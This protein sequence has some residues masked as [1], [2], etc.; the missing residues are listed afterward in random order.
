MMK[1]ILEL[2]CKHDPEY[3]RKI[4]GATETEIERLEQ[5]S[6]RTLPKN[7]KEFLKHM[8]RDMGDLVIPRSDFNISTVLKTYEDDEYS[9]PEN[10]LFIGAF[11]QDPHEDYYLERKSDVEVDCRVVRFPFDADLS[12]PDS[13][14]VAYSS[15]SDML[16]S[17][18]FKDKRMSLLPAQARLIPL[19]SEKAL[20]SG[21]STTDSLH[22]IGGLAARMGFTRLPHT[23]S[24]L[25]MHDRSDAAILGKQNP[26][27][28]GLNVYVAASTERTLKHLV[29]VI[30]DHTQLLRA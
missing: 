3:P 17:Y 7:Y 5:L 27:S 15:L 16:F 1:D 25:P 24:H 2:I 11:T 10:Y 9:P 26:V 22:I 21:E 20:E 30:T 4:Y 14:Y 6:R 13:I 12:V 23:S 19:V 18:A 28:H 29:Q 8:G